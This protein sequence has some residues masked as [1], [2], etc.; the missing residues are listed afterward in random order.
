MLFL[1]MRYLRFIHVLSVAFFLFLF[2]GF[3]FMCINVPVSIWVYV[4]CVHVALD[5]RRGCEMPWIWSCRWLYVNGPGCWESNG[6]PLQGQQ[7]FSSSEASFQSSFLL[8]DGD[9]L[10]V[11]GYHKWFIHLNADRCLGGFQFLVLVI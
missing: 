7:E 11:W 4:T 9:H 1:S 6:G 3:F 10:N 2:T 8:V 5:A